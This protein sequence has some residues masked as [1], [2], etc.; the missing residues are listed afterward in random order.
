MLRLL[1]F[2]FIVISITLSAQKGSKEK[3]YSSFTVVNDGLEATRTL[4][5]KETSKLY[6]NLIK[7]KGSDSNAVQ[8]G[9]SIRLKSN[10]LIDYINHVK[11]LLIIKTEKLDKEAVIDGDTIISLKYLT[12]FDD[13][14]TPGETLLGE[15]E[16]NPIKGKYTA[17]ELKNKLN[18]YNRFI[19]KECFLSKKYNSFINMSNS[20]Y[21][22]SWEVG[23][24]FEKP[25]A[26]IITYLSK[27]QL[28]ITLMEQASIRHITQTKSE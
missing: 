4:L 1:S 9:D 2:F 12:H 19:E 26:G 16:W 17:R 27:L 13:Y 3:I 5:A 21:Y 11:I 22:G 14:Y 24:F 18:S 10:E 25:L 28:D 20:G 7:L 15:D 6:F 8:L 23:N